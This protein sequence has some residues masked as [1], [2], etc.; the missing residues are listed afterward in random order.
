MGWGGGGT[1]RGLGSEVSLWFPTAAYEFLEKGRGLETHREMGFNT[2]PTRPPATSLCLTRSVST[3][4]RTRL[5]GCGSLSI[6]EDSSRRG[7]S[8]REMD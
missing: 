4:V 1:W 8:L 2:P 3:P 6:P 7:A 5:L